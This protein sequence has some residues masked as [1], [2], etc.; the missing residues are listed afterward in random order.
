MTTSETPSP[1]TIVSD[2]PA[3]PSSAPT[4]SL[5]SA[6]VNNPG[7]F[8][9]SEPGFVSAESGGQLLGY[10]RVSTGTQVLDRQMDAIRAEGCT[11]IFEDV[12]SGTARSRP[13]LDALLAFARP[14]DTIIVLSLDRLGR[15]VRQLLQLVADLDERGIGL[16][17]LQLGVDT[18]TPAGRMVMTVIAA[19][20]AMEVE[21]LRERVKDGLAAARA[22][23]RVGGRPAS[24]SAVQKTEA[25]RLH[26]EGRPTG[27]IAELFGCSPR[28]I[29]RVVAVKPE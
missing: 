23:G 21:I 15:D 9:D 26:L 28:T 17:I 14:G 8:Y 1:K 16:R 13:Q 19:L 18:N 2:G 5:A 24:L 20:A 29:L 27:E 6:S 10:A 4:D 25:R 7:D 12:V 11:Q 3:R 22:R